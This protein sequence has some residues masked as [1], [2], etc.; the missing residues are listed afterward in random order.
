MTPPELNCS[1][2]GAGLE[3]VTS[4]N[5]YSAGATRRKPKTHRQKVQASRISGLEDIAL[6]A[7]AGALGKRLLK[8][9][10]HVIDDI[11]D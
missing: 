10:R 1:G 2:C 5:A 11:L 3:K 7:T 8:K 4:P 9:A 6:A